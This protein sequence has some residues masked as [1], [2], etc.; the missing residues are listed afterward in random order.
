M[1]KFG[2]GLMRLPILDGDDK[3]IDLDIF[4]EMADAFFAAGGTYFDTAYPYHGGFSEQALRE[5]VVKRYD[6]S[7]FT[8]A[9]KMP[10]FDINTE[11]DLQPIFDEQLQRC[12][13]TY[14]DYYML[15]CLTSGNYGKVQS[16]NAFA[17][18]AQK[19]AEGKI[20]RIGFSFHDT[21]EHLE[22]ILSDHPEVEFVQLQL[23]YLDWEDSG[24]R[25]K[26]CYEIATAHGKP[27]IVMEPIKGGILAKLPEEALAV[28]QA[29]NP[30]QSA[31]SWAIRF[32][33]G[34]ENVMMVLSGM[35]TPEQMADN[36]SFMR[37][38]HPLDEAEQSALTQATQIIRAGVAIPC[39]ACRYCVSETKC[40]MDIMIPDYFAMYNEKKRY[41]TITSGV[42]YAN[43]TMH[44]GKASACI[45]CGKCESHC[46]QHLPIRKHLKEVAELLEN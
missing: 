21:P 19:K 32:A 16:S 22:Q 10:M 46:P 27:V 41:N 44:H 12:G 29:Q 20:R 7:T 24:V 37:A 9:D 5:V 17:F 2:F 33:A 14:F 28:L 31:A 11:A 1:E 45:E 3:K 42:Y 23:N 34:L 4:R 35:S 6:R 13:V 43:L 36:L 15:H 26:E 39:T 18:I 25:A 38:F 30:N 8:V 40:P